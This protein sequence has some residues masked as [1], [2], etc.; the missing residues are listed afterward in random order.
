MSLLAS[1]G[2]DVRTHDQIQVDLHA[3]EWLKR[4]AALHIFEIQEKIRDQKWSNE[5]WKAARGKT[6]QQIGIKL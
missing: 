2:W 1:S 6:A 5:A 3:R 4:N